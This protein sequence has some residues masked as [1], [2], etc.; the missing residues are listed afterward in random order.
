LVINA[1]F[2]RMVREGLLPKGQILLIGTGDGLEAVHL[3]ERGYDVVGV[4][5][6]K[7]TVVATRETVS[8]HGF[9]GYFQTG[10]P[11]QLPVEDAYFDA[12]C[13]FLGAPDSEIRRVLKRGGLWWRLTR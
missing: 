7:E 11:A 4:D 13:D 5:P 6:D 2:V 10:N 3:L 8:H 1:E 9:F 12:V